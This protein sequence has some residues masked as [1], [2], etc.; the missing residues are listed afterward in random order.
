MVAM[1]I[2]I[3]TP[4]YPPEL[5]GPAKYAQ[6]LQREYGRMG[7]GGAV[8]AYGALERILPPGLRHIV[9]F[10]R[11]LPRTWGCDAILALDTWS[12]GLP[13]LCATR[14][15]RKKLL[16]RIGGDVLWESYVERTGDLLPYSRFYRVPRPLSLKERLMHWGHRQLAARA[17]A[18]AFTTHYQQAIWEGAYSTPKERSFMVENFYSIAGKSTN[19]VANTKVFVSAG[20][21]LKLKNTA[22][23]A[24][25]FAR[26][27][28][29]HPGIVLDTK[30]LPPEQNA[31]RLRHCYATTAASISDINPNLVIEG[32]AEGKPF[33]AP[34]ESGAA[35]RLAGLGVFADTSDV[36]ALEAA[37]R[38]LLVPERY[39]HYVA[40]IQKTQLSHSWQEIAH[41]YATLAHNV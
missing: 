14:L 29:D 9:Y 17:E 12:V 6:A 1:Q 11:L 22:R 41:E 35:E 30:T 31:E 32:V 39:R 4:L 33:V 21:N 40:A 23:L 20:R 15:L 25:A 36:D 34:Q 13:A 28:R 5:G 24:E 38:E 3:A 27:E 18:L 8:V 26:V 16:V 19:A 2:L 10:F 7:Y 37:I